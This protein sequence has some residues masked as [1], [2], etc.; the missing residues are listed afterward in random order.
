MSTRDR[1]SARWLPLGALLVLLFLT[2]AETAGQVVVGK[3]LDEASLQPIV[4]AFVTLDT[5][6]GRRHRGVLTNVDGRYVLRAGEPG[7]YRLSA[8]MIGYASSP[9]TWVDLAP[10]ET[11]ERVIEVPVQAITLEGIA[12][13]SGARCRVRPGSGPETARL[14]E[15]TRKALEVTSWAEQAAAVRARGVRYE[16]RLDPGSLRVLES[17]ERGWSGWFAGSPYASLPAEELAEVGYV[18]KEAGDSLLYYGPD[19]DVLLSDV[20]LETHCFR[21]VGGEDGLVG[22]AFEPVRRG[23]LPDVRGVL[24]LDR[25]SAELRK[26]DYSYTRLPDIP[27]PGADLAGG[28]VEFERLA[29]GVWIIRRWRIRMPVVELR[30]LPGR[31]EAV[32]V[33]LQES[34]GEVRSVLGPDGRPLAESGGATLFGVVTDSATGRPLAGALVDVVAVGRTATT[35]EEGAFRITELGSGVYDVE[36]TRRDAAAGEAAAVRR[37]V[38]LDGGRATRLAVS[39]PPP[40]QPTEPDAAAGADPS[41]AEPAWRNALL[42]TVVQEESRQP[43]SGALVRVVD[44]TGTDAAAVVTDT[45]GRFRLDHPQRGAEYTLRV[46]HVAYVPAEGTVRFDRSDELRIEVA[47]STR[48]LDLEP[49]VVTERRRGALAD[50]GFYQRR[51]AGAG[52]FVEVDESRRQRTSAVSALLV[53]ERMVRLVPVGSATDVRVAGTERFSAEGFSDCQPAVYLDGILM[54]RGGAPSAHDRVLDEIVSSSNVA[55]VE[56]FRQPAEVPIRYGGAG[57][58]CGVILLWT[59]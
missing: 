44:E 36:I 46:E 39:V 17:A 25:A 31:R 40:P 3:V 33:A 24:W 42:G 16:R 45:E 20:F 34:G 13:S 56:L 15:E 18:R 48:V 30:E 5:P 9:A 14:W 29:T 8:E 55:G 21:V 1:L 35:G 26:L 59:R 41:R 23:A 22:L 28:R 53:G 58:A 47:L 6:D 43:V 57:A 2:P 51:A 7:R 4:G 11:L 19:A 49:I 12:V 50:A 37:L 10:G 38:E 32:V 27:A 52:V 54:R